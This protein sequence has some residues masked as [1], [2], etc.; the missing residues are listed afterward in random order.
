MKHQYFGDRHDFYKYD[1]LLYLMRAGLGFEKL[2]FG[3]MLTPDDGSTDGV[4]TSYPAK[5]RDAELCAWLQ[6]RVRRGERD[7]ARLADYPAIREAPWTYM[8]VLDEVPLE[9]LFRAAY[10]AQIRAELAPATL[11]FLDPD[12]GLMVRSATWRSRPKYVDHDEVREFHEAMNA[13]SLLVVFQHARREA[14]TPFYARLLAELADRCGITHTALVAP[15]HLVS[16]ILIAKT[17]ERLTEVEEAL[18]P[19]LARNDFSWPPPDSTSLF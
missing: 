4:F 3:V 1:L 11:A 15:D 9:P 8:A 16:Y 5:A 6:E 17:A 14:R 19:Y 2:L 12:N 7:V 18:A 10:F 13:R